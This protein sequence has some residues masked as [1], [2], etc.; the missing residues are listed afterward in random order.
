MHA[1]EHT[2]VRLWASKARFLIAD[3]VSGL[4]RFCSVPPALAHS[5]TLLSRTLLSRTSHAWGGRGGIP[6]GMPQGTPTGVPAYRRPIGRRHSGA[7]DRRRPN[8]GAGFWGRRWASFA[9]RPIGRGGFRRRLGFP[10]ANWSAGMMPP[11]GGTVCG[12]AWYGA[13][14]RRHGFARRR[15]SEGRQGPTG[16]CGDAGASFKAR[17]IGRAGLRLATAGRPVVRRDSAGR[18]AGRG[19]RSGWRPGMWFCGAGRLASAGMVPARAGTVCGAVYWRHDMPPPNP[20]AIMRA[21]YWRQEARGGVWSPAGD[22]VR[23]PCGTSFGRAVFGL[24]ICHRPVSGMHQ[25]RT[26][27]AEEHNHRVRCNRGYDKES[28]CRPQDS[29]GVDFARP[30]PGRFRAKSW[31]QSGR[32]LEDRKAS[33]R[34]VPERDAGS[35]SMSWRT[36]AA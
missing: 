7:A 34:Q 35:G 8:L 11:I 1:L 23:A 3:H 26:K 19:V 4:E 28:V 29:S 15:K 22:R 24:T 31:R 6:D 16:P 20:T 36:C 33:C 30:P 32:D 17:P 14:D 9:S 13:A 18:H 27:V 5:H 25:Q 21:A 10:P 12:A 2:S